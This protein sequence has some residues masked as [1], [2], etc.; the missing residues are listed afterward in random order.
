MLGSGIA[1]GGE[2]QNVKTVYQNQVAGT[3]ASLLGE[4]FRTQKPTG[5]PVVLPLPEQRVATQQEATTLKS[6]SINPEK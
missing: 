1:P 6:N 4:S 5:R 2:M 3:V